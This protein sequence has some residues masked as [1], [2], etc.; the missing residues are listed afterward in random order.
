MVL[1]ENN[2]RYT[3]ATNFALSTR[4]WQAKGT[5]LWQSLM[6][7]VRQV[8]LIANNKAWHDPEL[9]KLS[10]LICHNIICWMLKCY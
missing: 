4:S 10:V 7:W 1:S 3:G 6:Y 2:E 8:S 5:F 9:R